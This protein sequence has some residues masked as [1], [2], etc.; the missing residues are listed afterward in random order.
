MENN[1][2]IPLLQ[3]LKIAFTCSK[4]RTLVIF[5]V[6]FYDAIEQLIGE[7]HL[8]DKDTLLCDDCKPKATGEVVG[9]KP[10]EDKGK[11]NS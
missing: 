4:C 5:H 11:K 7:G 3:K 8:T 2:R 10:V 9:D 6:G 1:E